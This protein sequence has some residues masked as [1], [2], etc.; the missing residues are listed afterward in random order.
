MIIDFLI[1]AVIVVFA[2]SGIKRGI[3]K[4]L[5][6]IA[7]V[8]VTAVCAYYL[9]GF[10]SQV[11]YDTFIKQTVISNVS[12]LIEENGIQYAAANSLQA[13]PEWIKS[14]ISF[15]S[16]LFGAEPESF[17]N[18]LVI[19][20]QVSTAASNAVESA[21]APLVKTVIGFLLIILLFIIIFIFVKKLAK[22][23]EKIFKIPGI[24]QIN[25]LFG[26]VLGIAEGLVIVWL[27]VNILG[28]VAVF[29]G[30]SDYHS[31]FLTS[32]LFHFFFF[33]N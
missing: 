24:K 10:L 27:A 18:S 2:I 32:K 30:Q 5:L 20:E 1:I 11:I 31:I 26:C 19:S 15:I 21:V 6:G 29:S 33:V 23:V 12:Q 9:S 17:Q 14:I 28:A 8:A 3:A 7:S 13:L 22:L 4:T 16:S 25:K